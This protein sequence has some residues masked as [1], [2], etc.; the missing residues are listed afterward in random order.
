MNVGDALGASGAP[1]VVEHNGKR[2]KATVIG[3]AK[4]SA[5]EKW[6]CQR[7]IRGFMAANDAEDGAYDE[8]VALVADRIAE[9]HYGFH[10]RVSGRALRTSEGSLA[11]TAIV[12]D[13]TQEQAIELLSEKRQE[14]EAIMKLVYQAS[15]PESLRRAAEE[16]RRAQEAQQEGEQEESSD[17]NPAS[18]AA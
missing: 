18:P 17:P 10:G 8:A 11:I 15:F 13:I 3:Q 4:K 16:A 6:L 14:V 9:G 2:Y 7:V 5:F 1:W 12:F